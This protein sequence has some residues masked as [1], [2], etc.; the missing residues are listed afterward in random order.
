MSTTTTLA[1]SRAP[2]AH[3]VSLDH[4]EACGDKST[5]KFQPDFKHG[6]QSE[7]PSSDTD[8]KETGERYPGNIVGWDGPDDPECPRNWPKWKKCFFVLVTSA[9]IATVSFGS[10]VF[11]PASKVT[12]VEF[13]VSVIVMRLAVALWILGFF[14]G[15]IFF[16][17]LSELF[18]HAMV[19]SMAIC[20]VAI[21]QLPIALG[22]N[23]QT[24]L[25]SRFFSGVFGSAAFA[26]VSGMYVE[27]YEPIPRG[28]ALGLSSI[29]INLGAT[30]APIAGAYIVDGSGSQWR[31]TAWA[32]LIV[33]ST[34]GIAAL[35]AVRE[36]SSRMILRHKAKRL[37]FETGNWALHSKSE[38]TRVEFKDIIYRYLT[39]P[40]RMFITEPILIIFTIYLTLVYGTLYLSFQAFPTAFQERGWSTRASSLPF[41]AVVCGVISAWGVQSLFTITWYKNQV[42]R[43]HGPAPPEYRLPPMMVGAFILPPSLLWF[44]WSGNVHPAS[45]IIAT[46]FIGLGLMLIFVPGISYIV[47]V[48][49]FHSNSAMSIHVIVR[50]LIACSFPMFGSIMYEKLGVAWASSVLAFLCIALAPAPL[51][52]WVY[53]K[54]IRSW[55]SFAFD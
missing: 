10:S 41:I 20:G 47:D 54:K 25:I 33:M 14:T 34:F 31:W 30:I 22:E 39:K 35:F 42:V 18:G 27:L 53:G 9:V 1:G 52:F 37:R 24:I 12:A 48:Y 32:T 4:P 8:G 36:S 40:V 23:L 2:S 43:L 46:Y 28:V 3:L 44:G 26:T 6:K 13:D 17:P 38:E 16:G 51:L 5:S 7:T 19:F 29:C 15:P 11:A 49:G 21:F 55:S 50:S 45:Q